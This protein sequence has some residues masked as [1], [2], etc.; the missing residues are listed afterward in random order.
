MKSPPTSQKARPE[1]FQV[2]EEQQTVQEGSGCIPGHAKKRTSAAVAIQLLELQML[3]WQTLNK[4]VISIIV[5][6]VSISRV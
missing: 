1:L 2:H 6:I 4:K 3:H 5:L